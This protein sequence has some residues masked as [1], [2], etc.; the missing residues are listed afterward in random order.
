M[1]RIPD[2]NAPNPYEGCQVWLRASWVGLGH[3]FNDLG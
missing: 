2:L 1:A 3:W